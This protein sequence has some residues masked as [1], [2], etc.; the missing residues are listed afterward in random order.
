MLVPG[1]VQIQSEVV[2]SLSFDDAFLLLDVELARFSCRV[3]LN[4]SIGDMR[5]LSML[6]GV[7]Q[8]HE[9]A[10]KARATKQPY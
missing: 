1:S 6:V 2:L 7:A 3:Y 10:T 8:M 9:R 5:L 4:A